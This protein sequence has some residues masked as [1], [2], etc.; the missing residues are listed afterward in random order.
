MSDASQPESPLEAA[1]R[2]VDAH[3]IEAFELLSHEA[4]LAILLTLWEAYDPSG[5]RPSV[6]FSELAQRIDYESPGNLN[7]HLD[8]LTELY[9]RKTEDGYQN[10]EAG[11]K[12]IRAI[13]AGEI[14]QNVSFGP[15]AVTDFCP[16]FGSDVEVSYEDTH[17]MARCT[18]CTGTFIEGE[19]PARE[20]HRED[21]RGIITRQEFP[22]AGVQN[23][24]PAA[25]VQAHLTRTGY[26]GF[27][28]LDGT[29][30]ECAGQ[31]HVSTTVCPEH[32]TGAEM[33]ES[34]GRQYAAWTGMVCSHCRFAIGA[35][36]RWLPLRHPT[37]GAFFQNHGVDVTPGFSMELWSALDRAD[38]QILSSE[39]VE[40]EFTY[41]ADGGTLAATVEGDMTVT[42][43]T[44]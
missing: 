24:E 28:M 17:I 31:T 8:K 43:I 12:V 9:V 11:N 34:C 25:A 32:D 37:V 1:I 15:V 19:Q 14:T 22:P 44:E 41:R 21:S 40:L 20:P 2:D 16:Y 5:E 29:C 10:T 13:R 36:S 7:Y 33:C 3:A 23:R 27:A 38:E 6:P 18:D 39:P 42:E 35:P 26:L 30:P 4:R